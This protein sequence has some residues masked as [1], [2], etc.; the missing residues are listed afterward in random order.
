MGGCAKARDARAGALFP[1]DSAP[2]VLRKCNRVVREERAAP[3]PHVPLY[4]GRGRVD[5]SL[6]LRM[7][8]VGG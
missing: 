5:P 8:G 1:D 7:T 2:A 4:Y 6:P 3:A